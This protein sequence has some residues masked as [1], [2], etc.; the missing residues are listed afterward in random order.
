MKA[1]VLEGFGGTDKL[2][3]VEDFPKPEPKCDEVLIRVK[4]VALNHLDIWV[5]KG[6]LAVK[7]ELPHLLGSDV[8]GVV[9]RVGDSVHNVSEGEEVIVSPG[10]SC[11]VC[12]ECRSGKDNLCKRYDIL[13]L[14]TKG[15]YGEYVVVPA[16]NVLRK[17]DNLS[18]EEAASYPLTFLTIW[19]ALV[20]KGSVGPNT[21]V[22]VWAGSSGVGVAGIQVAKL[23]GAFVITTAG[24][25]GRMRKCKELGADVVINHYGEDVVK[26]VREVFK[27]GVDLVIDHVG[28]ATFKKSIECLR[29]GGKLLFF[30]TTTGDLATIDI[31][32]LFVREIALVGVYMGRGANLFTITELF[33]KGALKPVVDK[34]FPLR[35]APKAHEYLESGGHFGKVV[36]LIR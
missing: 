30:G 18:F 8:S 26:R 16:R 10:L 7:P 27:D 24:D 9:E 14:K 2:R 22:L 34:T 1:V 33:K 15:G 25:E 20:D 28:S 6:A 5:R 29:R 13:G 31:R 35:D 12:K 36:L 17:P 4:A 21:R 3:Y 11:G 32:Y 23:F 19:N